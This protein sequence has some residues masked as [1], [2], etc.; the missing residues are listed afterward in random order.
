MSHDKQQ[1]SLTS[2]RSRRN[3]IRIAG[4]TGLAGL[5]GCSSN[6]DGGGGSDDGG[7]GSDDG[8]GGGNGTS[9]SGQ[10]GQSD[11]SGQEVH[12]LHEEPNLN[13][14]WQELADGFE[15][16]TGATLRF[17]YPGETG[18]GIKQ[19]MLQLT[20]AGNPPEVAQTTMFAASELGARDV[21]ID[22]SEIITMLEDRYGPFP[23][24]YLV[25]FGG[26]KTFVPMIMTPHSKWYRSDLLDEVP[27]TWE[28]ELRMA[29]QVDEGE[30]GIR[31]EWLSNSSQILAPLVNLF[32]RGWGNDAQVCERDG[33]GNVQVV[34]DEEPYR[35]RWIEVFEHV[36]ELQQYSPLNQGVGWTD[37]FDAIENGQ[38]SQI[39]M[40]GNRGKD[41]DVDNDFISDVTSTTWPVPSNKYEEGGRSS[42]GNTSGFLT[43]QGS[44]TEAARQFMEYWT[45]P[46][47]F[48]GLFMNN[49]GHVTPVQRGIYN[50]E[51]F[52][53]QL[54]DALGSKWN[55]ERDIRPIQE[56][57]QTAFDVPL[58]T[59]PPNPMAGPIV[60]S[61]ELAAAQIDVVVNDMSI[62]ESID[63]H[64]QAMQQIVDDTRL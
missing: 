49:P 64:A 45:R 28:K 2:R 33:D 23:D 26:A 24:R 19:R 44:N 5:A 17:E 41:A 7:G 46:E 25:E 6:N 9:T 38:T 56:M 12:L 62:E 4:A 58:E 42:W 53:S 30:G 15:E 8:G 60:G 43:F 3:F 34:M 1:H 55:Y 22:H 11:I 18:T 57:T 48:Y 61:N 16:E 27:N 31:G 54:Q 14:Y 36:V 29:R 35:S 51:E 52:I 20:Q 21:L 63:T 40:Y 50:D 47:N 59:N 13:E 37:L 39:I 32:S 10:P